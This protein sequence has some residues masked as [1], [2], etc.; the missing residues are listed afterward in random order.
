[1]EDVHGFTN[2]VDDCPRSASAWL[3][4]EGMELGTVEA[5]EVKRLTSEPNAEDGLEAA[6]RD[7]VLQSAV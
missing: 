1:L 4:A 2:G 3:H 5:V 6:E 7:G